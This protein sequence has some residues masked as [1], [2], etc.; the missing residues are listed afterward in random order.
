MLWG[1]SRVQ[2]T[3]NPNGPKL[4]VSVGIA[5]YPQ[6]GDTIEKLLRQADL[7]LYAMKQQRA[8]VIPSRRAAGER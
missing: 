1:I 4:S 3:K 8:L 5:V 2:T 7:A 6:D